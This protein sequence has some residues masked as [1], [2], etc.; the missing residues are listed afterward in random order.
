MVGAIALGRREVG[1]GEVEELDGVDGHAVPRG[2]KVQVRA[3][4]AAGGAGEADALLLADALA[5]VD[6]DARQVHVDG[7]EALAVV[8][9]DAV[10][11]IEK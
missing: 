1:Q 8:E 10:A 2:F 9:D 4:H 3:G 11:F 7:E 6:V 5:L